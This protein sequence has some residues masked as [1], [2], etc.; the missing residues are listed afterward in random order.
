[1]KREIFSALRETG[2]PPGHTL[3]P[4]R[5]EG[6]GDGVN[7]SLKTKAPG[8]C[9]FGGAVSE[10]ESVSSRTEDYDAEHAHDHAFRTHR[11]ACYG[12]SAVIAEL[13]GDLLLNHFAHR[14]VIGRGIAVVVEDLS[15]YELDF[16]VSQFLVGF[17]QNVY[18][19]FFICIS[20]L[21]CFVV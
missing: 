19:L 3:T 1:M 14:L 18:P 21:P 8:G 12:G 6:A 20:F 17:F 13:F 2:W 16:F 5:W 7:L 9:P 15:N 4:S 10:A 11:A